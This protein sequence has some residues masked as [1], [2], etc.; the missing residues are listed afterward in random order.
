MENQYLQKDHVL[1][2]AFGNIYYEIM[3]PLDVKVIYKA[4]IFVG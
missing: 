4:S 2:Q 1:D 3:A